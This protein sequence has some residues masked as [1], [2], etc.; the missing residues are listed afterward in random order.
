MTQLEI[1]M[2]IAEWVAASGLPPAELRQAAEQLYLF[3]SSEFS[4]TRE[5]S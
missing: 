3:V 1:R 4:E 5:R 2:K